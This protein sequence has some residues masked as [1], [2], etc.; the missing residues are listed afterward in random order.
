MWEGVSGRGNRDEAPQRHVGRIRRNAVIGHL[1]A[2]DGACM[3]DYATLIRPTCFLVTLMF[4]AAG[5]DV[6]VRR[7]EPMKTLSQQSAICQFAGAL[8]KGV[9]R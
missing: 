6:H 3:A 9:H 1:I 2:A 7:G 5:R 8:V 4:V